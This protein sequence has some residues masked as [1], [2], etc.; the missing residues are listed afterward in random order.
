MIQ[1]SF[2]FKKEAISFNSR[3]AY[4][5]LKEK[6]ICPICNKQFKAL[7]MLSRHFNIAH[8]EYETFT[9]WMISTYP[10]Y[11]KKCGKH[12]TGM[13]QNI[14]RHI[15]CS[16]SCKTYI[17]NK[18]GKRKIPSEIDICSPEIK[19]KMKEW[20][21]TCNSTKG[22]WNL[23]EDHRKNISIREKEWYKTRSSHL[24]GIKIPKEVIDRR[25]ETTRANREKSWKGNLSR[26]KVIVRSLLFRTWSKPIFERDNFRCMQCGSENNLSIH[27]IVSFNKLLKEVFE[28]Y[29]Y[30]DIRS[31]DDKCILHKACLEYPP[32]SDTDN[33]I[34]LCVSC[35]RGYHRSGD[36][37]HNDF[38][39]ERITA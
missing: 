29:P 34:T 1:E 18:N 33:G 22:E 4:L 8:K 30:L 9:N 7:N 19:I 16:L 32:L 15:C 11:C 12:I 13:V 36:K 26:F 39:S 27:H 28:Q 2:A 10:N 25:N 38:V 37:T 35:H 5:R 21:D 23:S 17:H 31:Y 3:M 24:K 6:P 14:Y 20:S